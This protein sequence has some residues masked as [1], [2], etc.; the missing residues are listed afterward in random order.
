MLIATDS[1]CAHESPHGVENEHS[2]FLGVFV[3][4][5][6]C[7]RAPAAAN[8]I[9]CV[10]R[11]AESGVRPTAQHVQDGLPAS[12]AGCHRIGDADTLGIRGNATLKN[13]HAMK[14]RRGRT[15]E[16]QAGRRF[17]DIIS[18]GRE[19]GRNVQTQR[20]FVAKQQEAAR[21]CHRDGADQPQFVSQRCLDLS[22]SLCEGRRR[23]PASLVQRQRVLR[24]CCRGICL[25][26]GQRGR[27]LADML[28]RPHLD[29]ACRLRATRA[30]PP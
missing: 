13:S 12:F 3:R 29:F 23:D 11:R 20:G 19:A 14:H 8:E 26:R 5:Q 25:K 28:H 24:R 15:P 30:A 9:Q 17:L 1:Q 18:S 21:R 2:F 16:G 4:R 22:Q 27:Q 6:Q 7:R 10:L